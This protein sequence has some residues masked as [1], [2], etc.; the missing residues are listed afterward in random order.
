MNGKRSR[1]IILEEKKDAS[2]DGER[3]LRILTDLRISTYVMY[4]LR[5]Y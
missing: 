1:N 5:T 2:G 4:V 3:K